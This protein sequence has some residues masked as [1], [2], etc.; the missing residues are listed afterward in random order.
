M[1][2]CVKNE[3]WIL[4]DDFF[5]L[6]DDHIVILPSDNVVNDIH[7][8][9]NVELPLRFWNELNLIIMVFSYTL[10]FSLLEFHLGFSHLCTQVKLACNFYFFILPLFD[11][12]I[13]MTPTSKKIIFFFPLLKGFIYDWNDLFLLS[14]VELLFN[15]LSLVFWGDASGLSIFWGM[16]VFSFLHGFI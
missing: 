13:Q 12:G 5:A 7:W 3:Y 2:V 14:L 1:C 10:G 4:S 16:Y 9:S 8:F 15:Y 6:W 11:F